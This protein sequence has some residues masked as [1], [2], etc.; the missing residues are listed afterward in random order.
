MIVYRD[1]KPD[2]VLIFSL[3]PDAPV[4]PHHMF[5]SSFPCCQGQGTGLYS[6]QLWV[7]FTAGSCGCTLQQAVV[8]V[9]YSRQLW[10]YFTAGSCCG[11]NLQQAVVVDLLYSRQL[12]V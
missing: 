1:M 5:V 6:R 7:Y 3:V 12:W 8:G 2:N 4:C 10:V 11:F 9:L